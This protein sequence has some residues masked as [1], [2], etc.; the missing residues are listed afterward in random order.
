MRIRPTAAE[1]RSRIAR[2]VSARTTGQAMPTSTVPPISQ[3]AEAVPRMATEATMTTLATCSATRWWIGRSIRCDHS[4]SAIAA[5]TPTSTAMPAV[6]AQTAA[7]RT[8]A[9]A[10]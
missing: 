3:S 5:I 10:A 4:S 9:S 7:A 6:P 2:P 8:S 1:P